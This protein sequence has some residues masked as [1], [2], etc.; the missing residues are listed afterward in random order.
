[1]SSHRSSYRLCVTADP[2][3]TFLVRVSGMLACLDLVPDCL[4]V[5][6]QAAATGFTILATLLVSATERQVDLLTRKIQQSTL[7]HAVNCERVTGNGSGA[8]APREKLPA[9][10]VLEI[11]VS[12]PIGSAK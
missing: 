10:R 1:M 2:D 7:V 4:D 9:S 5:R 8:E 11:Y 12:A 6:R 3:S